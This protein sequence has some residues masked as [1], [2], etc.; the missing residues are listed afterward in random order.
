VVSARSGGGS[1]TSGVAG[2]AEKRKPVGLISK[3]ADELNA[4]GLEGFRSFTCT[5]GEEVGDWGWEADA[6]LF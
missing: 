4:R 6:V 5:R 2:P 1:Y 3:M